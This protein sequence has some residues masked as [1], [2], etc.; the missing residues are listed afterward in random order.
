MGGWMAI[1]IDKAEADALAKRIEDRMAELEIDEL[2]LASLLGVTKDTIYRLTR[3]ETVKRWIYLRKVAQAL[4]TS[5]NDLLGFDAQHR[6][7]MKKF[8]DASYRGLGLSTAQAQNYVT[9]FLEA[10]DKQPDPDEP[11][12]EEELLRLS[13]KN[14]RLESDSR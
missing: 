6:A 10:L 3:G 9:L 1:E 13:I 8:L 7:R 12:P 14:A 2:G 11:V 5:P 4:R